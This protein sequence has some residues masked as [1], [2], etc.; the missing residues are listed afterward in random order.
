MF[1]AETVCA[2]IKK[3]ATGVELNQNA[4]FSIATTLK[5]RGDRYSFP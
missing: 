5:C 1:H 3:L 2:S 4:P